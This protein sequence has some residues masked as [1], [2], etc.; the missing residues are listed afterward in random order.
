MHFSREKVFELYALNKIRTKNIWFACHTKS[1]YSDT[2]SLLSHQIVSK[3]IFEIASKWNGKPYQGV[4]GA[5]VLEIF[6][7]THVHLFRGTI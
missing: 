2:K 5:M 6:I 4:V 1:S 3:W 7:K